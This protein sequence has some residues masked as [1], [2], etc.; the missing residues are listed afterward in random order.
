MEY[1]RH[2][3]AVLATVLA[4]LVVGCGSA[5]GY[6]ASE[7]PGP[8]VRTDWQAA[9]IE[10]RRAEFQ[11]VFCRELSA[12][13]DTGDCGRWI[14]MPA[15]SRSPDRPMIAPGD[16]PRRRTLVVIPG[17]LGECVSR[18]VNP[19][20]ADYDALS[21]MG[22]DVVVVP[23]TGRGS[24]A[25]N[26]GIIHER[27][28]GVPG[29]LH[30][31]VVV[32]YSK[33][34]T[35]FM[36]ASTQPQAAAWLPGVS[37]LVA[38]AGTVNGSPIANRGEGLYRSVL[39]NLPLEECGPSDGGGVESIT[40]RNS[41]RV[42]QAFAARALP[43]RTYSIVAITDARTVNPVL[44]AF[45]KILDRLDERNDG[46]VVLEDAIVPG[47]SVLGIFHADHWAITL[48]FSE[49]GAWQVRA[50]ARNNA[51]PRGAL[52]RAILQYTAPVMSQ[53]VAGSGL[54]GE[55]K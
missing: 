51:F 21:R 24:A 46:Q 6:R 23:V 4:T 29:G 26:A 39:L 22:Y 34:V 2:G 35:D 41:M 27:L 12:A 19:F 47:S 36:L 54:Q 3:R 13:G 49:S 18:W 16:L 8:T 40:Y 38:V 17:I 43:I 53:S 30:D 5:G 9:G 32:A 14:A 52:I 20:S 55:G 10:D 15:A 44:A 1:L 33:G 28:A 45:H 50:L 11:R 25:L 31:A 48:P 37:V 42:A 7:F